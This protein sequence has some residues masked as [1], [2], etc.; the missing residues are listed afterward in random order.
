VLVAVAGLV[1]AARAANILY[2]IVLVVGGLVLGFVPGLLDAQL[3]P[4]LVL[5]L[6][7]A[8]LL[9]SAAFFANL[10]TCGATCVRSRCW[11]SG[12]PTL[13]CCATSR[14]PR[15][16]PLSRTSRSRPQPTPRTISAAIRED[17]E[18]QPASGPV[19]P[20]EIGDVHARVLRACRVIAHREA[21]ADAG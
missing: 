7:P 8:P 5:V 19:P 20:G 11:R 12:S 17:A 13:A 1:A 15:T 14:A 3:A 9:Y 4:D 18:R 10:T 6:F 21:V 2:P 16:R